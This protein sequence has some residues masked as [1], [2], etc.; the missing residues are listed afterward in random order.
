MPD[1]ATVNRFMKRSSTDA[2]AGAQTF[3][4]GLNRHYG[5]HLTFWS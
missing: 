2:A 3:A 4:I 1:S 5:G